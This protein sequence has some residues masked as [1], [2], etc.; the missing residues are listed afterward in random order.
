MQLIRETFVSR[1]IFEGRNELDPKVQAWREAGKHLPA[2]L[3]DFHDQKELF[4]A[5]HDMMGP[6][7]PED[8][9]KRPA[10]VEG[11][12]Y[13]IDCFL[14]FMARHGYTM[15]KSRANLNFDQLD[16]NIRAV[17]AHREAALQK[18]MSAAEASQGPVA[19]RRP[20]QPE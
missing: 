4:Q 11:Q 7:R 6:P 17:K 10:W 19:A 18:L 8:I 12:C 3:K 20:E 9:I 1:I 15:Q 16:E 14:W 5:M 13:V 2:V